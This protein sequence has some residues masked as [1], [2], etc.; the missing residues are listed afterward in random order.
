MAH[1]IIRGNNGRRQEVD[2]QETALTVEFHANETTIELVIEA[3][4]D[5]RP[6]DKKR[7]ALISLPRA[8]FDKAVAVQARVKSAPLKAVE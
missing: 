6:W 8:T 2:F 5:D 1:V 4:D 7:F 3:Q